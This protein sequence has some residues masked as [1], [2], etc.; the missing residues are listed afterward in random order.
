MNEPS[1]LPAK[2]TTNVGAPAIFDHLRD[3]IDRLFD[4]F[5]FPRPVR[6]LFAIPAVTAFQPL[7]EF[8]EKK[9]HYD[10]TVELPGMEQ[11]DID[12][13]CA[14]GVLTISGE[15]REQTE[16]K[17]DGYLVSERHYGSFR[18][19]L[20][21]PSDVDPEAIDAKFSNGVLRLSLKK[22]TRANQKVKKIAIK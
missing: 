5:I 6:S 18:R 11:K 3:E 8:S 9:D 14:E 2:T 16:E 13:E 12:I 10:L 4:D 17:S 20:T 7:M 15:K 22:D 21:L 1:T 19:R